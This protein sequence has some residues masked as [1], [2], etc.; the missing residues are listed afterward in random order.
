[1]VSR[2]LRG[3]ISTPTQWF[4]HYVRGYLT[5]GYTSEPTDKGSAAGRLA[6]RQSCPDIGYVTESVCRRVWPESHGSVHQLYFKAMLL[7]EY[8]LQNR[9]L[10]PM[11]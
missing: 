8:A 6:H 1:M 5:A 3:N 2:G 9:L 7:S 11:S 10:A 4:K